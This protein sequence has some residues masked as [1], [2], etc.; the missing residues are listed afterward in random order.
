MDFTQLIALLRKVV[1]IL[2]AERDRVSQDAAL[3]DHANRFFTPF[4]DRMEGTLIMAVSAQRVDSGLNKVIQQVQHAFQSADSH[5]ISKISRQLDGAEASTLDSILGTQVAESVAPTTT[6]VPTKPT[7][8]LLRRIS[9]LNENTEIPEGTVPA[10]HIVSQ[11][12]KIPD[13]VKTDLKTGLEEAKKL[14]DIEAKRDN[15]WEL[16]QMVIGLH[17]YLI[18]QLSGDTIT[19]SDL[20]QVVIQFNKYGTEVRSRIAPVLIKFLYTAGTWKKWELSSD[21][22]YGKKLEGADEVTGLRQPTNEV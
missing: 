15:V 2:T 11:D 16:Q 12:I 17:E 18:D 22:K 3:A 6:A 19:Y 9:S 4:I 7:F 8:S 13:A 21:A 20:K 10:P 14:A 5:L 1:A